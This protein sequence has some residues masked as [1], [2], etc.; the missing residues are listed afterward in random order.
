MRLLLALFCLSL[1][2]VAL[3]AAPLRI[4][5]ERADRPISFADENGKPSGFTA[6][7]VAEMR[8]A[9]LGEVELVLAPWSPLMKRFDAGQIDVLANVALTTERLR[10]M[11]FSISHAYVHGVIYQPA[12]AR[13][14]HTT[15][16]FSGKTIATLSG[17]ISYQNAVIHDGWGATIKPFPSPQAAVDAVL[18]GECDAA[19][20]IYGLERK[21]VTDARG[22]RRGLVDDIIYSFR[23]AVHKGDAATLASLNE[24]LATVR[25]DGS[26]E[27][28]Y[29]KWISPI[30]QR[31]LRLSDL[32][33]YAL[34]IITGLILIAAIIWWQRHMLARV[35][36]HARALR[37]SEER[38]HGLVDS[39]FEGW[40]IHQETRIVLANANFAAT[41]SYTVPELLGKSILDLVL[42]DSQRAVQNA[43]TSQRITFYEVIGLRKDG[44]PIPIE[45]SGQP[46][47]YDGKPARIAAV[48]DLTAHKQA[49]ADQLV[50]SKLESTGILAGGI[51]HD[52]NNL[53]AILVLNI[54]M[55]L[56]HQKGDDDVTR[57]LQG[58]K[59]AAYSARTLTQQLITF[60]H[61]E[62]SVRQPTDLS[63]LLHKT[64]PL[65]LS[66]SNVRAEITAAPHLWRAEIDA[67]QIERVIGNLVLN[68]RESMPA[69]G[70]VTVSADNVTLR[71]G[72]IGALPGGEYARL[73]V[74]DRGYGIP[75]ETISKIFDPYFSTKRRGAQKGMGLGL[76]IS[77]SILAQQGG[78]LT[79]DS[80]V[81]TG[82]TFHVYLPATRQLAAP[83][84]L[85]GLVSAPRP[86][87]ILVMDDET[88][89]RETL[90]GALAHVGYVAV[91]AADGQ[92][93]VDLYA[94]ALKE[95]HPFDV[96]LL[97][98]TVRGGMGGLEAMTA[99]LAL[100]PKV[101]VIVMSGYTQE[102]ILRDYARHGFSAALTKPFELHKLIAAIVRV[103]G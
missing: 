100:D 27:R 59:N 42:P 102:T 46:C 91:A 15:A 19:L 17:S 79:V 34:S 76:T 71:P 51:A 3:P 29:E 18:R 45:I 43:I 1:A 35:S 21:Y 41:F 74:T 48:R 67:G 70:V 9:G 60:A 98:L 103:R 20:L 40:V 96:V 50:L 5:V 4:G 57:F 61:G 88:V 93:A 28:L 69:G 26:F 77:H 92:T 87:R 82:T 38:F 47:T 78:T 94:A 81:G 97:D 13:P 52:F 55:A 8:R 16:D 23:F 85:A 66:G 89:L 56:V 58:A 39:A 25:S 22:L 101:N 2:C 90:R 73:T 10:D 36:R 68:A 75:A 54:D 14:I 44:T 99:L 33:P 65:A 72:E 31:S 83:P 6:D 32:K 11:D 86:G 30:E 95:S 24:A 80:H 62:V 12:N 53:L 37:E 84:S 64:V 49:A 63:A 7:L